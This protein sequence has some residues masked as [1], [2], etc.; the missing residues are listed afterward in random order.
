[1]T[2]TWSNRLRAGAVALAMGSIG[3]SPSTAHAQ[4]DDAK[5]SAARGFATDGLTA[6][7]AG[8]YD[9][10]IDLF[11]R[12]ES[13]VHAPPHLLY[14]ARASVKVNKLV[15]AKEM[16]VKMT[17]ETLDDKAP[18]AF[19]DAQ[20]A[21]TSELAELEPRIPQLTIDV[22]GPGAAAAKVTLDGA[23]VPSA[24]IGAP[25]PADPGAH[26][27]RATAAGWM[28]AETKVTLAERASE[29]AALTIDQAAPKEVAATTTKRELSGIRKVSPFIAFGVGVA[30]IAVGTVFMLKN[31][32]DRDDADA[33]CPGGKCPTS[34]KSDIEDLDKKAD[35]AQTISW[36]G[37]GVGAAGV[38]AGAVLLILNRS[39]SKQETSAA[40]IAPWVGPGSGG[41]AGRF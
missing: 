4:D 8:Q 28:P 25:Q 22:A 37:Y 32:G 19:V 30:G 21:A 31:H 41:F 13:L 38:V 7:N 26:V 5:R 1:M 16:Y 39:A 20:S 36:I 27:L 24:L 23:E 34:K 11:T 2:S 3:L 15:H 10:A 6:F 33:L 14:I 40:S 17:R 29:T 12:A 35:S 18:K 9:K